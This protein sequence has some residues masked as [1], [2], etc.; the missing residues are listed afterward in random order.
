MTARHPYLDHDG[1]IA[2]AHR[3]GGSEWPENTMP[4]F[5]AAVDLG[6]QY[7]ETDVHVTCDGVL[8]AFHDDVL[9]RVTNLA[10]RISELDY[11]FVRQAKV[12]G[13]EPIPKFEDLLGAWPHIR[14]NIDPKSD[15]AVDPLMRCLEKFRALDRVCIGSFSG[16][17]LHRVRAAFGSK[18]CTSMAPLDVVRLK[19][20][21]FGLPTGAFDALCAQVPVRRNGLTIV[22]RSFIKTAQSLGLQVH[23]WTIDDPEEMERLVELG[24]HGIMSGRP[25]VLKTVLQN[26]ALWP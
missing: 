8:L 11:A 10:G 1:V 12:G 23:V 24:V 5:E 4:A 16:E 19:A 2:F 26:R 9:D 17:R 22:D 20:R 25:S 3:G 15:A 21:Q 14:I 6:F 13:Q 7:L 18:V